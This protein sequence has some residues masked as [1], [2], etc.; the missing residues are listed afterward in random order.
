MAKLKKNDWAI[1]GAGIGVLDRSRFHA[2]HFSWS[3]W[4][5]FFSIGNFILP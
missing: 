1:L 3:F 5:A 2:V 4:Q